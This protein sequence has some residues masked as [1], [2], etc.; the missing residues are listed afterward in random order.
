MHDAISTEKLRVFRV[1]VAQGLTVE[2]ADEEYARLV[3]AMHLGLDA[4]PEDAKVTEVLP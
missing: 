4:L 3:A 2:A 1:T